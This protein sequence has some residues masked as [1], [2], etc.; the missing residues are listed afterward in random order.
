MDKSRFLWDNS[1]NFHWSRSKMLSCIRFEAL[2]NTDGDPDCPWPIQDQGAMYETI[3]NL[4]VWLQLPFSAGGFLCSFIMVLFCRF[5]PKVGALEPVAVR[6]CA[7]ESRIPIAAMVRSISP[8]M[9]PSFGRHLRASGCWMNLV[10]TWLMS[11]YGSRIGNLGWDL[12]ASKKVKRM[13]MDL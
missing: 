2:L 13:P 4:K 12:A 11:N 7:V 5:W 9:G 10:P 6:C 3:W 1:P 8:R